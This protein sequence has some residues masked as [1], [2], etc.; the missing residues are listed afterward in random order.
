MTDLEL[1]QE[2]LRKRQELDA[3]RVSCI[4]ILEKTVSN[5]KRLLQI[6]EERLGRA[7]QLAARLAG[8]L[9][10]IHDG[11][12]QGSD[13]TLTVTDGELRLALSWAPKENP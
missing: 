7:Q 9:Q 11:S 13:Q 8:D 4:E 12:D 1:I 6:S 2:V 10:R 3:S 5:W